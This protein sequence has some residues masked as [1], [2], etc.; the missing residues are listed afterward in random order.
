MTFFSKNIIKKTKIIGMFPLI[1]VAISA[2]D[3]H[4][5]QKIDF[6]QLVKVF[7]NGEFE[8]VFFYFKQD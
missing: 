1:L 6:I 2:C 7:N 3:T 5:G 4:D 8:N